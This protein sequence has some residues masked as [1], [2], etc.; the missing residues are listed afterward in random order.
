[1]HSIEEIR[2]TINPIGKSYGLKRIYLFGSYAKGTATENSD[3]D[4]LIEKSSP[5]SLLSISSLK[6]DFE[7]SLYTS[8]DLVTTSGIEDNFKRAIEGTELLIY[9]E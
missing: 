1:M 2:N 5:M 6:Q 3:V 4:L 9:E 7:D 8:V